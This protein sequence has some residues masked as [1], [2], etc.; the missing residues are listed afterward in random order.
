MANMQVKTSEPQ[1]KSMSEDSQGSFERLAIVGMACRFPG[2]SDLDTFWS[3]LCDGVNSRTECPAGLREGRVGQLYEDTL[4]IP[5]ACRF[6]AFLSDIDQF[7]AE[8]F[9]ISPSEA[10]FLDPQQRMML[11]TCWQALENANIDPL[12]LSGTSASVFAGMSNNDY[13]YLILD[14]ADTTQPAAS[15]Y[16]IT[17]TSLNTAIGRVSFALDLEGPA[18]TVDTACSSS[19]VAMHQAASALHSGET[20]LALVGGVQLILS[21]KLTELRANAGMLS[22]D[23]TCKTF[24]ERANGYV[25]GEGCGIVVLKRLADAE[26]DGDDIWAVVR[27]TAINQDGLSEGLT[28]PRG[29]AQRAVIKDALERANLDPDT[30]DY[31]EAHGTGTPVGDPVEINAAADIY[32]SNRESQNPLL[33]GSVKTNIGHLEPAAGVAGVIKTALALKF[34]IIPR[35]INFEKPNP[36]IDWDGLPVKVV[37]DT[38][39][40]P[41]KVASRR[42]AGI[43]SFGFSGTN[44]HVVLQGYDGV[45]N[46]DDGKPVDQTAQQDQAVDVVADTEATSAELIAHGRAKRILPLSAKSVVALRELATRYVSLLDER[47]GQSESSN[48]ADLAWTASIGRSH[49]NV[50]KGIVFDSRQSLADQLQQLVGVDHVDSIKDSSKVAFAYTG[51]GSQWPGMGKALYESEAAFRDVLDACEE[52]IQRE[53]KTTLIGRMFGTA[54]NESDLENPA[55]VQPA[56]YA[57]EC[58]L[59]DLWRHLGVEPDVV[60]GHSLGE[61]AAARTAGIFSLEDGCTFASTR[62]RLMSELRGPGA[63]AAVFTSEEDTHSILR[64]HNNKSEGVGISIAAYNGAHQVLSG[65]QEELEPLLVSLENDDIRVRRLAASPAYHSALVDPILDEL[66]ECISRLEVNDPQCLF[67]S[68]LTGKPLSGETRL[69]ADYWRRHARESVV[70]RTGVEAIAELEVN[71]ILE[72]G[73]NFVLGP[74]SE[75]CWP[76]G[77]G[78]SPSILGSIRMPREDHPEDLQDGG[79]FENVAKAYES[80]VDLCFRSLYT[81]ETRQKINLPGY[82]FQRSR[83]WVESKKRRTVGTD[84]PLLGSKRDS[85]HGDVTFETELFSSDPAWLKE[86]RVYGHVLLPGSFYGSMALA[87][88]DDVPNPS[89]EDFQLYNPMIFEDASEGGEERF[90]RVQLLLQAPDDNEARSFEIHSKGQDDE[91][92]VQHASG[93]IHVGTGNSASVE[94]IDASKVVRELTRRDVGEYYKTKSETNIQLGAPF[95]TLKNI[96]SDSGEA[97]AEI[98]VE[99]AD[100]DLAIGLHP[101]QLDACFQVLSA[102]RGSLDI[103]SSETYIPF[104]WERLSLWTQLPATFLCRA[105]MLDFGTDEKVDPTSLETLSGDLWFYDRSGNPLGELKGFVVKRASRSSV[106]STVEDP[107]DLFYEIVWRNVE[108]PTS[109]RSKYPLP[110]IQ[111]LQSGIPPFFDYL[112]AQGVTPEQ[113]YDLLLD[114]EKLAHSWVLHAFDEAGWERQIGERI[115]ADQLIDQFEISSIHT[116]LVHRMIELM[117]SAGI[118]AES[119]EGELQFAVSTDQPTPNDLGDPNLLLEELKSKH[120][121]GI[122]ELTLL[123]RFGARLLPLLR[124]EVD[125]LALLFDEASSGAAD[126]YKTAPVSVAGNRLLGDVIARVIGDLPSDRPL[127]IVEVGAGTGATS[128]IVFEELADTEVDYTYTDISAGFFSEAER[129]FADTGLQIDY[130]VLNIEIDPMEQG[131]DRCQYDIVIAANVLHATRNLHE[132]LSNCQELLVPGGMLI[133]LESLRGRA[134]QDMT[135]GFLDGWWRYDDAYRKNH[136]IASPKVWQQALKDVGYEDSWVF[137]SETISDTSGPLGSG[138]IVAKVPKIPTMREGTWVVESDKGTVAKELVELLE[139]MNQ[140]V[141]VSDFDADHDRASEDATKSVVNHENL[142]DVLQNLPDNEPLRGVVHLAALSGPGIDAD[143]EE[144]A[145]EVRRISSSALSLAQILM[146]S[147]LTPSNGTWFVTRGAQVLEREREGELTGSP[148]WGLGKVLDL[149]APH[150]SPRMVD[151]SPYQSTL[152]SLIPDLISPDAENHIAYR[153]GSRYIARL[154]R[155]GE[156]TNQTKLPTEPNWV[157]DPGQDG[158]LG[159]V[160]TV[161]L[162]NTELDSREV[163]IHVE[164]VGLNFSDVLVALGA[165]DPGASLGLEF[166]GYVLETADDVNEFKPGDRVVGMGFGTF[167]PRITTKADLVAHAPEHLTFNELAAI[168]IV[169]ATAALAFDLARLQKNDRV[170]VHSAAGGVGLA[171]IQLVQ[172]AGAEVYATAS[173]SKHEFLRRIGI[174]HVFDSRSTDFGEEI[175]TDTDGGGVDIVLNSLTSEG[176]IDASLSCLKKNGRFIEIG[177]LNIFTEEDMT[178]E[179]PDVDYHVLSLDD[180]KRNQ[181]EQVGVAFRSLME[182]FASGELVSPLHTAWSIA[183]IGEAIQFMGSARHIGKNV[184]AMPPFA[185]GELPS[186]RTFLITGGFGGIGCAVAQWLVDRGATSIVLNGRREPEEDAQKTIEDLRSRGIQVESKIAD[187]TKPASLSK[188]LEEIDGSLPP[189]GGVIHSVGVLSDGSIPNQNWSRFEE[190]LW[191]KVLGA[192]HL[193][194]ATKHLDL[195]MFVLFSSATGVMGNAGQANHAAANAFLDQLAAHRRSLGLAGQSIAWGAWSQIGEA[196]EQRTRIETQLES[197]GTGWI[198]PEQGIKAL[199]LI[200]T[201]SPRNVAAMSVD[202]DTLEEHLATRPPLLKE[203]LS[204]DE[205]DAESPLDLVLDIPSLIE[206]DIEV[207]LE[208][209]IPFLQ[210]QVQSILRL[211]SVP[212]PEV[213]FFDLGMDS[214]MAVE[215]RNRL[216]RIFEGVITVSNTAVFDFPSVEA[217]AEHLAKELGDEPDELSVAQ[218]S[219]SISSFSNCSVGVIGMA[220]RVPGAADYS[221]FWENIEQGTASISSSRGSSTKWNGVVGD[222]SSQESYVRYGGFIEGIDEF[223]AKFFG[224]LPIDARMMDPRQRLLLETCWEAIENAAIDADTLRGSR[225]GL[226]IGLGGSEYRDLI[227]GSSFDDNYLGTS[228]G[229]TTGRIAHMFGLMGPAMSFDLACASSLVAIHEG[230]K[231]LQRG[232]VD[233]ALVGGANALLSPSIMRFHR[234]IGLLSDEGCCVPFDEKANGYIRGEGCGILILRRLEDAEQS[235]DPIWATVAG[236]AV[237]QNGVSAG[238]TV[239]NGSAQSQVILDAVKRAEIAPEEVDYLEA[240]AT[241]LPQSDS[242]ELGA[243]ASIYGG[244]RE[245]DRPLFVGSVKNLI[246]HLEWAAGIAGAIKVILS[247]K[248]QKIPA[249]PAIRNLNEDINWSE[250]SLEVNQ[251]TVDWSLPNGKPQLGA[252]SAF[253]MSGTNAHVLIENYVDQSDESHIVTDGSLVVGRPRLITYETLGMDSVLGVKDWNECSLNR[254][255]RLLPLSG[256]TPGS[257]QALARKYLSWLEAQQVHFDPVTDESVNLLADMAWT[258]SVGR[259][260]FEYR[261][262]IVYEDVTDLSDSLA[263]FISDES[264]E[265]KVEFSQ[266]QKTAFVFSCDPESGFRAGHTLYETEPVIRGILDHCRNFVLQ[267]AD[268]D[269]LE[270]LASNDF[271]NANRVFVTNF[272]VQCAIAAFWKSIGIHPDVVMC[273]PGSVLSAICSAEGLTLDDALKY[274]ITASQGVVDIDE[275]PLNKTNATLVNCQSEQAFSSVAEVRSLLESAEFDM[276][277]QPSISSEK[278]AKQD[279][280]CVIEIGPSSIPTSGSPEARESIDDSPPVW[281]PWPGRDGG[282]QDTLARSL[283]YATKTAYEAGLPLLYASLFA[284]ESRRKL[285]I[286]TYQFNRTRYWFNDPVE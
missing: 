22:P 102:A 218:L 183:E 72:I 140:R 162:P 57:L 10:E 96:W 94:R 228:S 204:A 229:M 11:E 176:F 199:D 268:F 172:A 184:L 272:A 259:K 34:G 214:L 175:L 284:G 285:T 276:L 246:G 208:T 169:F 39:D 78:Q 50:R 28:V 116:K 122:Y 248:N 226:Y 8:F 279:V 77:Q 180:L 29:T 3:R 91:K 66:A 217:L 59:T 224:I 211:Q 75:I 170:L 65:L 2:A 186:D 100:A 173:T 44:A 27:S 153:E 111:D 154:V 80:G 244:S 32:G 271:S 215:L 23:G 201:Q 209:L 278:L 87:A 86:H 283:V 223:D 101:L 165:Q 274:V 12:M 56:I 47:E 269:V 98:S 125:P 93:K 196:A 193:H 79:F 185:Q 99:S 61:I 252:I 4:S 71:T 17:G 197:T 198:A 142:L 138:T 81:G 152:G 5:N 18:M 13:R 232:E 258:A 48:L 261:K 168:P 277:N 273:D 43:N 194:H 144:V 70:F 83:H 249:Q 15:L 243:A 266:R 55:W 45:D 219:D 115:D 40:W 231:A 158:S 133:A 136:A 286:P 245:L 270:L 253:G 264:F 24:D 41:E 195:S 106:L 31:L 36:A 177:R 42:F 69:D 128:E 123:S 62:G 149:E 117:S 131:F 260:H 151:L 137:G 250:L 58:A 107:S 182:R 235:G 35:H 127:R 143:T 135:F 52:V 280:D 90:R 7:D 254:S 178:R 171:A 227:S 82:P 88:A 97:I 25:R 236:S 282:E 30:V 267:E 84:H 109:L 120:P 179:R 263:S 95:R 46:L 14:G 148:L 238:L 112:N 68:N 187:V 265:E 241:G 92:W 67:V 9:R 20:D 6:G 118:L 212:S 188:M 141:I 225:V 114:L 73:P 1:A 166:A 255:S 234:E 64:D 63:M 113:R 163:R 242:I 190:V 181:S 16:T 19:L 37:A 54:G 167:G 146:E 207:R 155:F 121:H 213:G 275:V 126:F 134:W 74:M 256:R 174:Q 53:R 221:S 206:V 189:L 202:W 147:G 230:S 210:K 157:I 160:S 108:H 129:R 130:R 257:V 237:N 281:I 251:S 60:F 164:S 240:H 233:I 104:G 200:V 192:W 49:F 89:V 38:I 105:R 119:A 76:A 145:T 156:G 103:G 222:E 161:Q 203:L 247:M 191:P 239:P 33:I 124:E 205:S 220:C 51:Q 159:S 262:G 139:G 85:A 110:E 216:I 21:G 132:T 26:A 150:V